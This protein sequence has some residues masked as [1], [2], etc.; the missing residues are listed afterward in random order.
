MVLFFKYFDKYKVNVFQALVFNYLTA[1]SIGFFICAAP[2]STYLHQQWIPT[3][4][5]L[6]ILLISIFYAISQ[7][8]I[9]IGVSAATVANKMSLIIPV[10]AAFYFYNDKVTISKVIGI[11]LAL[12]AVY[13]TS[14]KEKNTDNSVPDKKLLLLPLL[15]FVGSGVID[16]IVNYVQAT[17]LQGSN[18]ELFLAFSFGVA[19]IIGAAIIVGQLITQNKKIELKSS[20]A[21][22]C[23]G[24]PNFFSINFIIKAL[25]SAVFESTVLF[26]VN[27][28]GVVLVSAIAAYWLFKEK[29]SIVNIVGILFALLAIALIA[30]SPN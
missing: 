16:V 18:S 6:G 12:L 25:D 7:T 2:V 11:L 26:P 9:R 30:I 3:S 24:I 19:F 8:T 20:I 4:L 27:N 5:V 21:G 15:V 28:M 1:A 22:V 17:Y 29:L 14:K 13:L 23:L 10:S